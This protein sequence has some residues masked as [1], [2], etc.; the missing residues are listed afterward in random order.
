[1]KKKL[2]YTV[3]F[4]TEIF[5]EEHQLTGHK[6]INLYTIEDNEPK[7]IGLIDVENDAIT[8]DEIQNYLDDN[9]Y[10]DDD[11]KFIQL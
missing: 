11:F 10:G 8:K 9:G 1:M 4:E 6:I 2:Y 7:R 5:N 3:D